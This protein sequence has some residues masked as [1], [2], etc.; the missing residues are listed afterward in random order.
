MHRGPRGHRSAH[1]LR[2]SA[3]LGSLR[4]P[5]RLVRRHV[6]QHWPVRLRLRADQA[7]GSRPQ[8]ADDEP[9]R[10]H[11]AA[12]HAARHALGLGDVPR[13]SRQPGPSGARRERRRSGAVLPP[14]RLRAGHEGRARAHLGD[15]CRAERDEA[16]SPRGHEGRRLRLLGRQE[17]RRSHRGRQRSAQPRGLPGRVSGPRGR[18]LGVQRRSSRLDHRDL[19]HGVGAAAP[20]D[21]NDAAQWPA[22]AR[23]RGRRRARLCLGQ[24]GPRRWAPRGR[25]AKLHGPRGRVH[26]GR[27]QHVRLHAPLDSATGRDSRRAR[28]QAPRP[29]APVRP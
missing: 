28:G 16:P 1:P 29:R 7:R 19:H 4:H 9:H 23:R 6:G 11:P 17:S 2:R 3:Q 26:P 25:S 18:A 21:G 24:G 27:I 5:V 15:R 13:V 22:P 8:H 20:P 12:L 14:A 10:G